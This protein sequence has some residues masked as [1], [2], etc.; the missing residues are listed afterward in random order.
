MTK[1]KQKDKIRKLLE[2]S[3]SDNEN[4]AAIALRQAM[5]LMNKH[6]LSQEEVYGQA[7]IEHRITTPYYRIPGWYI[8]LANYMATVS[9]CFL[10][11]V[12]GRS[13]FDMKAEMRFAGRERDVKNSLY[14]LTFLQRTLESRVK[15]YRMVIEKE[16]LEPVS[17]WV[18]SYRYGFITKVYQRIKESK[19]QFFTAEKGTGI[20]CV[21]SEARIQEAKDFYIKTH[22]TKIRT[23]ESQSQYIGSAL[24]AGQSDADELQL[25]NA[26]SGQDEVLGISHLKGRS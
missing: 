20:V 18:K 19:K 1:E 23:T 2:L 4:E 13:D 8:K 24:R 26:L 22:Q 6:N 3:M 21:D 10:V 25:N 5:S 15:E 9:G 17:M 14:L 7:M 16:G 11:Y 12:N